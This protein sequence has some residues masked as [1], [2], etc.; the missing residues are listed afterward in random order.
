MR[1]NIFFFF[2][3]IKM[4]FSTFTK[5]L[6]PSSSQMECQCVRNER[7]RICIRD[8]TSRAHHKVIP[9]FKYSITQ[10]RLYQYQQPK[11]EFSPRVCIAIDLIHRTENKQSLTQYNL[12]THTYTHILSLPPPFGA[13]E[14]C[15]VNASFRKLDIINIISFTSCHIH[16]MHL[17]PKS[18]SVLFNPPLCTAFVHVMAGI[19]VLIEIHKRGKHHIVLNM[20]HVNNLIKKYFLYGRQT[21]R[22]VS[23]MYC[24]CVCFCQRGGGG[25]ACVTYNTHQKMIA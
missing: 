4:E 1:E 25:D 24:E 19:G 14:K 3:N 21:V 8:S 7:Q 2:W 12:Q 16:K 17:P 9:C 22:I 23:A 11:I 6:Q 13:A 18:N 20:C 5:Y 10:N 15:E